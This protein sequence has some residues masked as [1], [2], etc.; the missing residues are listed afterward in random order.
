MDPEV[1]SFMGVMGTIAGFIFAMTLAR[2]LSQRMGVSRRQ[3]GGCH[4]LE[5]DHEELAELRERV[6][7]LEFN[8]RRTEELADRLEFAERLLADARSGD[9]FAESTEHTDTLQ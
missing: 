2:G 5:G 4:C 8:G 6:A 1:L 3:P 9:R 7:D